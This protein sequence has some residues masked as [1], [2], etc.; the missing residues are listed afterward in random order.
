MRHIRS[1]I[2]LVMGLGFA[3]TSALADTLLVESVDSGA[4]VARP[5]RGMTMDGVTR[6]YGEPGSR[7]GPVGEPPISSWDYGNFVVYFE[8][9]YV[10]HSVVPHG[11]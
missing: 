1:T 6:D 3:G 8:D 11:Q 10:I 4:G 7:S 5:D 9:Q 2:V